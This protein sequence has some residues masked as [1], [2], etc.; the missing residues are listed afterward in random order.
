MVQWFGQTQLG[1][2]VTGSSIKHA[3]KE[4]SFTLM[5][6][7]TMGSGLIIK[8]TEKVF[9]PTLRALDMK[10]SGKKINSTVMV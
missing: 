5:V 9:T 1:T 3:D 6:I 8:Q 7:F 10:V 2:K 4:N